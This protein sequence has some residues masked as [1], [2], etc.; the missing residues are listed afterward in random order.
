MCMSSKK[1]T[2]SYGASRRIRGWGYQF[3]SLTE[4]KYALSILEDYHFLRS[5]VSIYYHPA[6]KITIDQTRRCHLRYTPDF[7]IRHK[8]T[9][10]ATLVEI[11]P[12]A[13]EH[14][15][16]LQLRKLV[17]ENYIIRKKLDWKFQIIFDDQIIL[18]AEQL[19]DFIT[20][21]ALS[22]EKEMSDWFNDYCIRIG[23]SFPNNLLSDVI[24]TGQKQIP[25][26]WKQ[27][28]LL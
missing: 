16:Q 11:K 25:A 26:L 22:S 9:L 4:L 24:I 7:L 8:Q 28:P 27:L 17:A 21:S 10:Q 20:C 19:A 18:N 12:R 3:D 13:F 2:F 15:P 1:N 14:H 5:P 6:T 23:Y